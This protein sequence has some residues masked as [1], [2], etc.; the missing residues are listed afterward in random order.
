MLLSILALYNYKED[1][2]QDMVLPEGVNKETVIESICLK[3]AELEIIYPDYD[4]MKRAIKVWSNSE[5]ISWTKLY[6]SMTIEYNPIWNVDADIKQ[7]RKINRENSGENTNINSVQGFNS[8]SWAEANKDDG[9]YSNEEQATE[10]FTERRTGNIGVTASQDL[11]KKEREIADFS[12]VDHITD[13]FKKR[14][15]L[16]VY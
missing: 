14:F 15:C 9:D 6:Q 13:S 16:M 5:L 8:S 10:E 12:I 11:I 7:N 4:I 2:F 1:I 3:C